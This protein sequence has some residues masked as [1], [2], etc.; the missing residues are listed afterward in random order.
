MKTENIELEKD[1]Q[2]LIQVRK[3]WFVFALQIFSVVIVAILPFLLYFFIIN[4]SV[5]NLSSFTPNTGLMVALYTAW[6]LTMWMIM[7]SIWTNYYLDVWTITSKRLIAVDQK[8]F[9]V[10]ST[11]SF[12]L[13]RLQ[14]IIV[15]VN[16]ILPTLLGYGTLEVQTAGEEKNFIAY[17]LPNPGNLKGVI[18]QATD[19]LLT[20]ESKV[21]PNLRNDM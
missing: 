21:H 4:S 18:L 9:F 20:T 11:A 5:T 17:G 10:R 1:E 15:T 8:G 3:H 6:L 12:R 7:F 13:E 19:T 16:G 14:D 2:I